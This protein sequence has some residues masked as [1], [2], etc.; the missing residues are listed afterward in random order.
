MG[1]KLWSGR[2]KQSTNRLVEDFSASI[3]FD[4]RLYKEDITGSIA[5][6]KMLGQCGILTDEEVEK[7]VDGLI[8]IKREIERGDFEFDNTLEDIHMAIEQRLI[9][10]IGDTGGKLHTA[11]SRNDQ[12][13]VDLRLY[14]KNVIM[15]F[16]K[17][18]HSL[19]SSLVDLA[20]QHTETIM[21]GFTHLQHAQPIVLGHHLMAYYEMF[22][23]D[24]E[25]LK[26][27]L[28][29]TD[30]MPLGS[31]ALAGTTFPIDRK[32]TAEY[33]GFSEISRNSIDA[34]SDRDFVI[35]FLAATSLIMLHLSRLSE[36][37]VLW[38]SAEF[39]F[40]SISDAFCTGSSIMPQKKNPDVPELIRGK[41]GRVYGALMS[42]LTTMKGLPLAYNR[43][44]QEDKE[45]L[46]DAIDTA[47]ACVELMA[48]LLAELNFNTDKLLEETQKGFI[49][50]TDLADYLVRKNLPFRRAHHIT[51]EIVQYCIENNKKLE[52]LDL[53]EL[54]EFSNAFSED[55]YEFIGV[56]SSVNQRKSFGGTAPELVKKAI[57]EAKIELDNE[58]EELE[59]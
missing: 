15:S 46:F 32:I 31:A 18:L 50:A 58:K 12:I 13:A 40:V 8:E 26:D 53:N 30:V 6:C 43:D 22:R 17:L 35:E 48:R 19:K 54:K 27:C 25:R 57:K 2:F 3:D 28:K 47:V 56:E 9:E 29:R 51:G 52:E 4:W 33:L 37:L 21:P 24:T 1:K 55:I 42:L 10:K 5:H 44:L 16:F 14:L 49:T 39:D 38:N 36:E 34:V 11:R 20:E 7:I 45:P 59:L 41:T 23:R